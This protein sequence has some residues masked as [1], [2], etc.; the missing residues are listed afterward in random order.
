MSDA[1]LQPELA[2]RLL[3]VARAID[4]VI[5]AEHGPRS[6]LRAPP[7]WD[8]PLADGV[9]RY[10]AS[11]LFELW[12]LC[13][14]I[15]GLRI[16]WTGKSGPAIEAATVPIREPDEALGLALEPVSDDG[17]QHQQRLGGA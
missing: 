8:A 14:A 17:A 9:A 13:R 15:E 12:A 7:P 10:G 5:V 6:R 16:A 1:S 2:S 11:P 4:N 3:A